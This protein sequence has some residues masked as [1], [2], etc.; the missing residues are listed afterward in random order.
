MIGTAAHGF[1]GEQ[2]TTPRA[3][4]APKTTSKELLR[5]RP[6]RETPAE[7]VMG[8]VTFLT[9][10]A[11]ADAFGLPSAAK[12]AY[13]FAV[14]SFLTTRRPPRSRHG[15]HRRPARAPAHAPDLPVLCGSSGIGR[16]PLIPLSPSAHTVGA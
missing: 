6:L 12:R 9:A 14:L 7:D 13:P 5:L 8:T 11:V 10:R 15:E 4:P 2:A 1:S 16:S 3:V